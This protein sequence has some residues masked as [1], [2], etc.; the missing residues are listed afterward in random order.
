MNKAIKNTIVI[1][2]IILLGII[3]VKYALPTTQCDDDES[4]KI[5]AIITSADNGD[6]PS[7][8]AMYF[9]NKALRI[10]PLEEY[11]ALQGALNGSA[12]LSIEYVSIFNTRFNVKYRVATLDKLKQEEN[13]PNADCLI[14]KLEG[15]SKAKQCE[16]KRAD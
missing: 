8:E 5:T 13:S 11:W 16:F 9:Y 10:E 14:A 7:I 15:S 1:S 12:Q 6:L 3:F 2:S 4:N